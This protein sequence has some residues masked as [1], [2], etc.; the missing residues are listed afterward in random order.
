ME[1]ESERASVCSRPSHSMDGW[2]GGWVDVL[3]LYNT[4]IY[5]F[6]LFSSFFLHTCTLTHRNTNSRVVHL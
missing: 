1:R 6:A 2:M 5:I 4:Y 3:S